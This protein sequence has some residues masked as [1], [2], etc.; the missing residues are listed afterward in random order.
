VPTNFLRDIKLGVVAKSKPYKTNQSKIK[1]GAMT[2]PQN[3]PVEERGNDLHLTR[4]SVI[5]YD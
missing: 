5:K 1:R 2:Y 3:Q 4:H